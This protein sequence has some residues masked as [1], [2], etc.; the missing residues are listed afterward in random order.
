MVIPSMYSEAEGEMLAQWEREI[1]AI[2][3]WL[4]EE[5]REGKPYPFVHLVA[6]K[7]L[8]Q[9]SAVGNDYQNPLWR[10]EE[11]AKRT[12]WGG[13]IGH[14]FY[15]VYITFSSP[16]PTLHVP[17]SV[18]HKVGKVWWEENYFYHPIRVNDSFHVW[19]MRPELTDVT[20]PDGSE[21]RIFKLR[22]GVKIF[23]Q[24]DEVVA[25]RSRT[26]L[27]TILPSLEAWKSPAVTSPYI[28][29]KEDLETIDRIAGQE[30]IRGV[31][32]RFWEDVSVGDVVT[33]T[34]N[35]PLT[36]WDVVMAV[37][38]VGANTMPMR[39]VR[40]K[41]PDALIVDPVT[42]VSHKEIEIHF[43]ERVA[44]LVTGQPIAP[45]FEVMMTRAITN[46]IGDDGFFR[47]LDWRMYGVMELGTTVFARARV[48]RKYEESGEKLV[49]LVSWLETIKG[50]VAAAGVATVR[51]MSRQE[52]EIRL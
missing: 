5:P 2:P 10:D 20:N 44:R 34:V 36:A 42:G 22:G 3:G 47:K 18:G 26:M 43:S 35:G 28:Y 40:R 32:P 21:P 25:T 9:L 19:V 49:D 41:T 33:P 11:Y 31:K 14:P 38:G 7:E 51:L 37:A 24:R 12:R 23:N 17:E 50:N 4:D 46:W 1:D 29:S 52:L 45:G 39:E 27:I 8:L 6:T 48:C 13:I 15:A 16:W 30:E